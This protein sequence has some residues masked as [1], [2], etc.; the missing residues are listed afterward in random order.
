MSSR[1]NVMDDVPSALPAK[2][3][4]IIDQV[5]VLIRQQNKSFATERTYIHWIKRF[6]VFHKRHP[7]EMGEREIDDF[8][9]WL[10][11]QTY[12]SPSTQRTALNALVFLYKQFFKRDALVLDYHYTKKQQRVPVTFN[13]DEAQRV[14]AAMR[15]D[16]R[17]MAQLMYGCGLRVSEC[18]RLRIKDIDF[19]S[20]QIVVREGKGR[21][22][23]LTMLPESITEDLHQ[24]I[25]SACTLH[26]KDLN[27]GFGEVY[28]PYALAR[29]YPSAATSTTWQFLFPSATRAK[30]PRDG[31]VKRHHVHPRTIQR[32][33]KAALQQTAIAKQASCHTFRH[34]FATQLLV[35]G[36][37]IRTIQELLGHADVATTEIYTHVL[38]KGGLGVRSPIDLHGVE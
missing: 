14:I 23:R 3:V 28:L 9:N 5:R 38:N 4:K 25:R 16:R 18:L 7:N 26:E 11:T 22:D 15:G 31:R 30:D 33:V 27:E 21:K 24:Q 2:P 36:Y 10:G 19:G 29:K 12:C 34:T 6:I 1:N 17:L 32:A 8:L 13:A 37:D 20:H 35:R